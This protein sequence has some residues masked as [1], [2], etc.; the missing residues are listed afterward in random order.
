MKQEKTNIVTLEGLEFFAYHGV[1]DQE[2]SI[3]NKYQVDVSV[4][5]DF[6]NVILSDSINDAVNY[7]NIYQ[8]IKIEMER[9]SR[10]L[11]HLAGRIMKSIFECFDDINKAEV[12]V[13][14]YNPPI[15]GVG[16]WAKITLNY[17]RNTWE[18]EF[19]D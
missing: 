19:E 9:R 5:G 13:Y 6:K 17:D 11:E 18:K 7:S 14:K 8:V 3:G 16:K 10:L 4:F 2:Q 1:S 15:G 12:S